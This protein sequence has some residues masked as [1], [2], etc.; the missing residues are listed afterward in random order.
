MLLS[1][2]RLYVHL[3]STK[4]KVA[5]IPLPLRPCNDAKVALG[6]KACV[7][8]NKTCILHA[9]RIKEGQIRVSHLGE[10]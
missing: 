4:P 5:Q 9:A 7:R 10:A 6:V 2:Q 1:L 8:K 3:D